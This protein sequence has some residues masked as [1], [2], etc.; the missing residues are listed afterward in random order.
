MELDS[1]QQWE[2]VRNHL[3]GLRGGQGYLAAPLDRRDGL[4]LLDSRKGAGKRIRWVSYL[5]QYT[6][7]NPTVPYQ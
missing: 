5:V 1:N 3:V 4:Q 2:L 7:A 6:L